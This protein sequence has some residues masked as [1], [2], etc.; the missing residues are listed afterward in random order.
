MKIFLLT[1]FALL[2]LSSFAISTTNE[3]QKTINYLLDYVSKS[4]VV[5]IRNGSEHDG[6]AAAA[7]LKTK[8]EH[9]KKEIKTPGDF[10]R[11][12]ATRTVIS[13]KPYLVRFKNGKDVR[14]ADWLNKVL[15][16]YRE[17]SANKVEGSS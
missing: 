14:C 16:E 17:S 6:K 2:P 15:T 5:M 4:D 11:L 3:L 12:S 9:Y 7:H 13:G 10:I 1:L 8:Y